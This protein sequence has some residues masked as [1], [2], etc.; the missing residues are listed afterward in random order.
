[1][2]AMYLGWKE[3]PAAAE[4][5]MVWM[6]MECWFMGWVGSFLQRGRATLPGAETE[7]FCHPLDGG[8]SQTRGTEAV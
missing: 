2:Q 5:S 1:M 3:R 7:L 6:A 8:Q 4:L